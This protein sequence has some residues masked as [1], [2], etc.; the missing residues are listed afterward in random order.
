M[1][2]I[3]DIYLKVRYIIYT[4]QRLL[5]KQKQFIKAKKNTEQS[6]PETKIKEGRGFHKFIGYQIYS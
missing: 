4:N 5:K 6:I 2:P 3:N 1:L